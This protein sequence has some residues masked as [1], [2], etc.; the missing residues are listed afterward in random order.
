MD[1]YDNEM[2]L[3]DDYDTSDS[4]LYDTDNVPE[5]FLNN[6]ESDSDNNLLG[7]TL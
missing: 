5:L 4:E 6:N 2:T 7:S 3:E 1:S